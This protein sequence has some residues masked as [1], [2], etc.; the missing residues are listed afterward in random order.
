MG[1]L[2]SA[3]ILGKVMVVSIR[4]AHYLSQ[5]SARFGWLCGCPFSAA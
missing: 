2:F 3:A 1:T 5:T 4:G